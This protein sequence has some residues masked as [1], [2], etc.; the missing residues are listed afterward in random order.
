MENVAANS[1]HGQ[2]GITESS[3]TS[4]PA[5]TEEATIQLILSGRAGSVIDQSDTPEHSSHL[6]D[7]EARWLNRIRLDRERGFMV[8]GADVDF[9]LE[10]IRRLGP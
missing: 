4:S 5:S 6:S 8:T 10:V 7:A 3:A 9:V 2:V 1:P